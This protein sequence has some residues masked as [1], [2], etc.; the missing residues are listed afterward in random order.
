MFLV[1]DPQEQWTLTIQ[2]ISR[3]KNTWSQGARFC[4]T[5][6]YYFYL[7]MY[8]K[9]QCLFISIFFQNA[10]K[11]TSSTNLCLLVK[12]MV[13]L[14]RC[15]KNSFLPWNS[16]TLFDHRRSCLVRQCPSVGRII[17]GFLKCGL[18]RHCLARRGLFCSP[19]T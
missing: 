4:A 1:Q 3:D 10:V 16:L 6:V 5:I 17:K 7:D 8:L 15:Q 9:D 18:G 12:L 19:W 11:G 2:S 14:G 13:C